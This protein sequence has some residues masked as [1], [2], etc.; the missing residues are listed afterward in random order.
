MSGGII[1]GIGVALPLVTTNSTVVVLVTTYATV[2]VSLYP[3][4][5]SHRYF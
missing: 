3:D 4:M 2:G 5:S 1:Y